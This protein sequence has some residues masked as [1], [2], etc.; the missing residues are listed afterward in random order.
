MWHKWHIVSQLWFENEF[1]KSLTVEK[2]F[3]CVTFCVTCSNL[4]HTTVRSIAYLTWANDC[5]ISHY[6]AISHD[7]WAI[8]H[9]YSCTKPGSFIISSCE[10]CDWS[11][12]CVT[13]IWACDTKC[14][15]MEDF[16]HGQ[17]LIELIFKSKLWQNVSFVPQFIPNLAKFLEI[18]KFWALWDHVISFTRCTADLKFGWLN[19][20][21]LLPY[22]VLVSSSDIR[23]WT[24]WL[25]QVENKQ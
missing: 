10:I 17:T 22:L 1:Y 6:C 2:I 13:Q 4:C 3:N 12:S 25:S 7:N 20:I 21:S 18:S 24:M 9:S 15:T 11:N 19:L 5:A 14:D 16:F 23:V 8:F